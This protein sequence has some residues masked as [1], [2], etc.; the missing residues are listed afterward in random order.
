MLL[1]LCSRRPDDQG[2]GEAEQ[3]LGLQRGLP[4]AS[5][6]LGYRLSSPARVEPGFGAIPGTLLMQNAGRLKA[7]F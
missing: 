2:D 6:V 5:D 4:V 1:I 3:V 7:T